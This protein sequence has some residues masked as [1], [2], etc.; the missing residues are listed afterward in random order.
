MT[1]SGVGGKRAK[2]AINF[3]AERDLLAECAERPKRAKR[4]KWAQNS[5]LRSGRKRTKSTANFLNQWTNHLRLQ[6][7]WPEEA[8]GV[9]K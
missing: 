4:A 6:W 9:G 3:L 8:L 5:R 2:S 1:L 7:G